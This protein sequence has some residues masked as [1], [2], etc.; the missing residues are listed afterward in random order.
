MSLVFVFFVLTYTVLMGV[1]AVI[2]R[3]IMSGGGL[4][5]TTAPIIELVGG[6]DITMAVGDVL[7]EPTIIVYDDTSIPRVEIVDNVNIAAEGE[8]KIAYTAYD[9][10]DNVAT[11][12]RNVKVVQPAGRVYLT[13][14]DGPSDYT[15][16]LLDTL[17]KY[18]VKATFFVTGYGDDAVLK[19]EYDEGHAVGVHTM[20]HVY[21]QIYT[22]TSN[23]WDDFNAVQDRIRRVTGQTTALMRF[24]GG[25]SN[26]ISALYDGGHHIMFTLV[27][28][29]AARGY[30]YFDW[31]VDSNDA[32]GA[33][34]AD[35][36]YDN[37]SRILGDG[38]EYVVLQ[39]D[40]KPYSVEA[41][42]RIIQ[43]G[44]EHNFVFSALRENSFSAHHGVNN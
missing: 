40:V 38:G 31:N 43:Y 1:L 10:F 6:N 4:A 44:L 9:E 2:N 3:L 20:S 36:V 12:E 35:E 32:G 14:D 8:Y 19:R 26:T 15:A 28:E 33:S 22:N 16:S 17:N 34:T 11:A 39:H 27:D 41:V 30:T 29:A 21:S 23:Y 24:P 18:G 7:V 13:F 5:D 25:S 42:E 37:V